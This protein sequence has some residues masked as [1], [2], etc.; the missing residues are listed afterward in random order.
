[1]FLFVWNDFFDNFHFIKLKA[2][3]KKKQ[4]SM[5]VV[6]RY[7]KT[8]CL[9]EVRHWYFSSR[10]MFNL[11]LIHIFV[12]LFSVNPS[13]YFTFPTLLLREHCA[14]ISLFWHNSHFWMFNGMNHD[15]KIFDL[16]FFSD[17]HRSDEKKNVHIH[18][19]TC[20]R[21]RATLLSNRA[22]PK[23]NFS[24]IFYFQT[25]AI[26]TGRLALE[27]TTNQFSHPLL[28]YST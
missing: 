21:R 7:G 2:R 27:T 17:Y 26:N 25:F 10:Y 13:A 6:Y 12:L 16:N 14:F 5:W 22:T 15:W 8:V 11:I 9:R 18:M 23:R 28:L 24:L 3:R 1:M 20:H 19:H 4:Q